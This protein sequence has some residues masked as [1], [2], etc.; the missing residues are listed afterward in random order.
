MCPV[1]TGLVPIHGKY[2]VRNS[3]ASFSVEPWGLEHSR[4]NEPY[5][6]IIT[7]TI[8]KPH[9]ERT[10]SNT[11]EYSINTQGPE[12]SLASAMSLRE[13][14]CTSKTFTAIYRPE[15]SM[16]LVLYYRHCKLFV[17]LIWKY[18]LINKIPFGDS[19]GNM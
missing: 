1:N 8:T 19:L 16:P 7:K 2:V 3:T 9:R 18:C 5:S 14:H 11:L 4:F 12:Y 6:D 17:I 10:S 15:C 13:C